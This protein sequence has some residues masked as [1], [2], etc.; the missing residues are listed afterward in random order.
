MAIP[1]PS[2]LATL[3]EDG[4]DAVAHVGAFDVLVEY[5]PDAWINCSTAD[6]PEAGYACTGYV[7]TVAERGQ[8]PHVVKFFLTADEVVRYCASGRVLAIT[9]F[10]WQAVPQEV[11]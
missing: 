3:L 10:R 1:T 8:A 7:L 11:Q 9:A 5:Q 6:D 4:D 2:A